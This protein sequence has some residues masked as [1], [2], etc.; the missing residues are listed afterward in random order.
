MINSVKRALDIMLIIS[1]NGGK[2]V[3]LSRLAEGVGLNPSTCAHI[4]KT[5][6]EN[7]FLERQDRRSGY[8]LGHTAYYLTRESTY[9]NKLAELIKPELD[10]YIELC[11]ENIVA[12]VLRDGDK[13][14]ICNSES[15]NL[16]QAGDGILR[17]D[18]LKT[19]TGRLLLAYASDYQLSRYIEKYGLPQTAEWGPFET[20][21]EWKAELARI[22]SLDMLVMENKPDLFHA[23]RPIF[24]RD[25][26]VF[27]L[28]VFMPTIRYH[29]EHGENVLARFEETAKR[30]TE[31]LKRN[32][33]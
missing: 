18:P 20:L 33:S 2:P 32:G 14:V 6:L 16:I 13:Y 15:D 28:G 3:P 30:I 24:C 27:A 11:N 26:F 4:V 7:G 23:A 8:T 17:L 5:L 9:K 29:G 12:A 1:D 21:D 19:P 10:R 22:R 25:K 31:L